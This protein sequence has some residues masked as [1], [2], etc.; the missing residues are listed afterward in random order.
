GADRGIF[1]EVQEG[2]GLEYRVLH[3]FQPQ[4]LEG[5]LGRFSRNLFARVLDTGQP[6]C[7][8]SIAEEA[9]IADLPTV[10]ALGTAAA[11]CMPIQAGGRILA[12]VHLEN[13]R[14]GHFTAQ[15]QEWLA[16]L[17][18]VAGPLLESLR[19]GREVLQERDR[20]RDSE[21]RLQEEVDTSRS[22]LLQ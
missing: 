1:V 3:G 20:L 6:G 8:R 18:T 5:D 16:S 12:L 4:R 14:P 15:H 13:R 11:P 22:I 19:V 9:A 21:S 17:L 2:G 10:K 7:L